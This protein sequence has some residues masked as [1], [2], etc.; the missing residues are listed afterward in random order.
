MHKEEQKEY[1]IK[2]MLFNEDI[3]E[4]NKEIQIL[5]NCKHAN[6]VGYYGSFC[7]DNAIWLVT[8]YCE[9]G[10]ALDL[11][12]V[13]ERNFVEQEIAA[14]LHQAL[15]GLTY[16]HENKKIHRDIKAGNI[17]LTSKGEAKLADFGVSAE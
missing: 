5:K 1:A 6:V 15:L 12:K 2:V 10:S 4:I 8:E 16:L 13:M 11:I 14:I 17:L 7:K 3:F 9:G